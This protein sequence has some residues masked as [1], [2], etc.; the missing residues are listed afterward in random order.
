VT[1]PTRKFLPRIWRIRV[2]GNPLS[3]VVLEDRR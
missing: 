2:S 3:K 1:L